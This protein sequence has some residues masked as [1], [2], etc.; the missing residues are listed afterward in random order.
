MEIEV[1][2]GNSEIKKQIIDEVSIVIGDYYDKEN[3]EPK[4][5]I[6]DDF[7]QAV[8]ELTED[9]TYKSSRPNENHLV[10]GKTIRDKGVIII[11]PVLFTEKFDS[12]I[13]STIYH[14]EYFHFLYELKDREYDLNTK[15]GQI[16][17]FLDFYLEEYGALRH[18][19]NATKDT[20]STVTDRLVWFLNLM[21][22]GHYE[23]IKNKSIYYQFFS[24]LIL[25]YKYHQIQLNDFLRQIFPK[26]RSYTL[27]LL[28]FSA[29][30]ESLNNE[31]SFQ[32]EDDELFTT[33]TRTIAEVLD[34]Y[35]SKEE[36][37]LNIDKY[38]GA[39]GISLKDTV[40]G[41]WWGVHFIENQE[42]EK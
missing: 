22:E 28:S 24:E 10:L 27:E 1:Q 37:I 23:N 7:K 42:N 21:A 20:F 3:G 11:N 14:H 19:I 38:L 5:L 32:I 29:Y 16:K 34:S 26:V 31:L 18:G 36:D 41:L 30:S 39:F 4:Y 2:I 25:K 17:S 9:Q 8:V 40:E 33:K 13:R 6:P 35:G 15:H 12:Q